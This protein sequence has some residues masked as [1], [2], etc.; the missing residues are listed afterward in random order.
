MAATALIA[1]LGVLA[2]FSYTVINHRAL[3]RDICET[4]NTNRVI[5]KQLIIASVEEQII[6][7]EIR[8]AENPKQPGQKIIFYVPKN[9][10]EERTK[11]S[12]ALVE[13]IDCDQ[14]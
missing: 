6:P 4:A 7:G 13:P 14:I 2:V 3:N 10:N 1:F 8:S 11:E 5:L 12:L 9:P